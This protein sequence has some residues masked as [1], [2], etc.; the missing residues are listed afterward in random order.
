MCVLDGKEEEHVYENTGNVNQA[1][2]GERSILVSFL[3]YWGT[4]RFLFIH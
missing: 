1:F 3:S 2:E 4:I